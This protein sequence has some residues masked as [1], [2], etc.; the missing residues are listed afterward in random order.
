MD[1][2]NQKDKRGKGSNPFLQQKTSPRSLITKPILTTKHLLTTQPS[3]P[4]HAPQH[5]ALIRR[6]LITEKHGTGLNAPLGGVVE[7]ADIR[8]AAGDQIT[9]LGL[10]TDL[11]GCVG[12]AETYDVLEGAFGGGVVWGGGEVLATAEFCPEDW[13]A[14]AYGRYTAPGGEE[15]AVVV[16]VVGV[17]VA[18]SRDMRGEE[19][20]IRGTRGVIRDDCFNDAVVVDVT[21]Q[22]SPESVLIRLR[23]DGRAAFVAGV[24]VADLLSCQGE[25]VEAGFSGDGDTLGAGL[26]QHWDGFHGG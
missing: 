13:E 10:Q 22:F 16:G 6:A 18:A 26:A 5:T 3:L 7:N 2:V 8:V 24:A 25:V 9:L 14:Q 23:A 4:N 12:A 21:I 19:F 20:K 15:A 17:T 1:G 11:R